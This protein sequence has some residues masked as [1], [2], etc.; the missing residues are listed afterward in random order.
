[1]QDSVTATPD[2]AQ[3]SMASL[4]AEFPGWRIWRTTDAGTWWASRCGRGWRREPRTVA[5]DTADDLRHALGEAG[6]ET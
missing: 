4:A 5:A 3:A 6:A 2:D 1:M